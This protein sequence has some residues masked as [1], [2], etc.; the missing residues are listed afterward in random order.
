[1]SEPIRPWSCPFCPLLCDGFGVSHAQPDGALTLVDSDC[2]RARAALA[3]FGAA[4]ASPR[5]AGRACTLDEAVDSA[6]RQ[7]AASRQPLFGG[8]GTDV[9]GARALYGLACATGAISDPA[10]GRGLTM[11]LRALQ[12]R[13]VFNTT[14]AEVKTRADLVVFFGG[15]PAPRL[16]EFARRVGLAPDDE[17]IVVIAESGDPFTAA[18]R[19]AALVEGRAVDGAPAELQALAARLLAARYAVLVYEPGRLPA[20]GELIVEALQRVVATLN[21]KT[22]AASLALGGGDGAATV[23]QVFAWLS[24]L[25]L[26]SRAGPHGLEHEPLRFDAQ[27]LLD[28]GGVDLLLWIASFGTEAAPPATALP[29]I[30]LGHPATATDRA[31][32]FIPVATPGIGSAGHLFRTD[33]VVMIPLHAVR[34]EPLPT[35]AEVL[36]RLLAALQAL[37]TEQAA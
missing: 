6:A 37:K 4:S 14:L 2:P 20:Q 26:R 7:L 24:G 22:R 11:G 23:N 16:P 12:D 35:V 31:G 32:V 8:L 36:Q 5:A 29:T 13:G 27:R 30:V 10:Q 19:L 18:A 25:P 33:G 34:P 21:R 3:R 1:M 28:D 15:A 17:R 9:A